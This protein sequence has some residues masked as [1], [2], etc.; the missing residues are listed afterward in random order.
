SGPL[1]NLGPAD[2]R[3]LERA[4]RRRRSCDPRGDDPGYGRALRL[5]APARWGAATFGEGSL[6]WT[7]LSPRW[8][9]QSGRGAALSRALHADAGHLGFVGDLRAL[10]PDARTQP[11]GV[12]GLGD[13]GR[14]DPRHDVRIDRLAGRPAA[15]ARGRERRQPWLFAG[16]RPGRQR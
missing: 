1:D 11:L 7:D 14:A 6:R 3:P 13:G 4:A 5:G 12:D 15:R 16:P 8:P 9:L 10:T 2:E